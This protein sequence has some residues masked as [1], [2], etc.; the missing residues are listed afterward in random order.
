MVYNPVH[1]RKNS[2][3]DNIPKLLFFL[4]L[5]L[6]LYCTQ[7]TLAMQTGVSKCL[8]LQKYPKTLT[9]VSSDVMHSAASSY[10]QQCVWLLVRALC[11]LCG[12][13]GALE[14][15]TKSFMCND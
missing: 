10:M 13:S 7:S 5:L 6:L 3:C 11:P 9:V 2:S 15:P 8:E 14:Y 4:L 12:C 1:D